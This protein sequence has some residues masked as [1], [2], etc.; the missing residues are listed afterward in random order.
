[1]IR[2]LLRFFR[3]PTPAHWHRPKDAP[4]AP[5]LVQLGDLLID[6]DSDVWGFDDPIALGPGEGFAADDLRGLVMHAVEDHS[7]AEV[8]QVVGDLALEYCGRD[9]E[10]AGML[11]AIRLAS[12]E[13]AG[14]EQV[15]DLIAETGG[16]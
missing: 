13:A 1:M 2:Q 11:I 10:A 15:G 8:L 7:I 14:Y 16:F 4:P 9:P 12:L 5:P 3:R 6:R